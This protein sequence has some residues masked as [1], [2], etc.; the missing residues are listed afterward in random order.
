MLPRVICNI[1]TEY[2]VYLEIHLLDWVDIDKIDWSQ[3]SHRKNAI[4]LLNANQDKI[5]WFWLSLN[6][7]AIDL[8]KA[9]QDK[10]NWSQL[11]H[12][13]NAIDIQCIF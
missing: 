10:I 5:D 3:L 1:I 11:S 6:P 8:L 2:I 4:D 9:T 7:N 13:K 12:N